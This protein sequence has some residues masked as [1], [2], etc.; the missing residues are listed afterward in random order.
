MPWVDVKLFD[1]RLADPD[2][3]AKLVAGITDAFCATFGEEVRDKTEIVIQG[4]SPSLWGFGGELAGGSPKPES[5]SE[6]E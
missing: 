1:T 2:A 4:V 6:A 3:A 5:E